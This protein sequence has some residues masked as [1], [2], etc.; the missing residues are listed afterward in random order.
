MSK[1]LTRKGLAFGALVALGSSLFAGVPANAADEVQIA[2]SAGTG[3]ATILG[4]TFTVKANLG[5]LVPSSSAATL[6][7]KVTNASSAALTYSPNNAGG[8]TVV[9]RNGADTS[10]TTAASSGVDDVV[11]DSQINATSIQTLGIS[12]TAS[13]AT[14]VSVVAFLDA[15]G[16]NDLDTNE[17][18]TAAYEV[19]FVKADDAGITTAFSTVPQVGDSSVRVALTSSVINVA[20]VNDDHFGVYVG[21]YVTGTKTNQVT[22]ASAAYGT[23]TTGS[24]AVAVALNSD[25]NKLESGATAVTTVDAGT[26]VAQAVY[27]KNAT[28]AGTATAAFVK[29][30]SE[31]TVGVASAKAVAANSSTKIVASENVTSLGVV[32]SGYTGDVALEVTVKD[33][34]KAVLAGKTVRLTTATISGTYKV[35]GVTAASS[36]SYDAVTNASGVATF[37]ISNS[38]AASGNQ[39]DIA[40]I[41]SEGVD[42]IGSTLSSS[43]ID[44]DWTSVAYTLYEKGNFA[45]ADLNRGVDKATSATLEVVALDQWKKA[46]SSS[47]YRVTATLSGR[48]VAVLADDLADGSAKFTITDGALTTGQTTV[49]LAFEELTGSTWAAAS[50]YT[51]QALANRV[52]YWYNQT[53]K[54]SLFADS[55]SGA[56][57]TGALAAVDTNASNSSQTTSLG[58]KVEITG[59]VRNASTEAAKSGA[60]ITISGA[61]NILFNVGN[62]W[63]FGSLTFFDADGTFA[64]D[65]YSNT[66]QKDSVV[67]VTSN[68]VTDTL[69]V[70]F[71]AITDASKVKTVVV[72][73][74]TTLVPGRTASITVKALDEFG[75][76]VNLGSADDDVEISLTGPGYISSTP[77]TFTEG[78]AT[79]T[80]IVGSTESGT[81][82]ISA[83]AALGASDSITGTLS[84]VVAAPAA[85]VVAEPVSKIGTANGRVYVNVKDAKGAVVS[86]KIG[87][88]WTTKTSLNNDYT[89]SFKNTKGKKVAVKVYVD[90]DLSA[91][92]TI[93]VK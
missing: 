7:F 2:A 30:G 57:A 17:F 78:S 64:V 45:A 32:R 24:D 1:N 47:S 91:A 31:I 23:L 56:V 79:F 87:S 60:Q 53:D 65:A 93:T 19:K 74:V 52:Y 85:P 43:T 86:V 41:S 48:S 66:S 69:K 82:V 42:V 9:A 89:F 90:G 3:N 26:Y 83:K 39:F 25:K 58:T 5:S 38:V 92:K 81:T 73:G 50:T 59:T 22:G 84:V 37:L 29:V 49:A 61:S 72:S 35:N 11:W 77:T 8:G 76:A 54:V 6:K 44:L 68:G 10:G 75:N 16:G 40:S 36:K 34:D 13:S 51:P 67:T 88:K 28:V 71:S 27:S 33:T 20:Q 80:L 21:K 70:T 46:L 12:T 18:Q 63:A 14:T 55:V 4:E 15:D 62:A